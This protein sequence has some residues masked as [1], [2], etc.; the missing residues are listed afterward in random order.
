MTRVHPYLL[1]PL[2]AMAACETQRK[3]LTGFDKPPPGAIVL[4]ASDGGAVLLWPIFDLPYGEAQIFR[5]RLNGQ[6][7]VIVTSQEGFYDYAKVYLSGWTGGWDQW[8]YGIPPGTYVVEL[9][10]SAGQSWGTSPPLPIPGGVSPLNNSGQLPAVLFTHFDGQSGSWT[11]DP[12]TQDSDAATDEITVT[13]L[14]DEDVAVERCLITAGNRT[15]CTPVGTVAPAADLFT[16]E[17]LAAVASGNDHPALV[18]HLASN[19][20]PSY[21]RD[22]VQGSS[23]GNFGSTCQ[24]ERIL[25]HGTRVDPNGGRAGA[26]AFAMSS[27]YGYASG[28]P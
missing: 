2:L 26:P 23:G 11:V 15:S 27:C 1:L 9:A 12:T 6:D 20:T 18:I 19:A 25:V 28:A 8:L 14:V 21:Q 24:V 22:L 17:T 7:A 13:N 10:D 16:V 3:P 4:D 5:P